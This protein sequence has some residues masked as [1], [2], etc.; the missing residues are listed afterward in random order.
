[1]ALTKA[2]SCAHVI[3]HMQNLGEA[4]FVAEVKYDGER[5][6]V[7]F[8]RAAPAGKQIT[9]YSKS[10][11]NSTSDR[12][13]CHDILLSALGVK[14]PTSS[15]TKALWD[16]CKEFVPVDSVILDSELLV[17]NE[18]TETIEPFHAARVF[19]SEAS[20]ST[21]EAISSARK[22][23]MLVFFDIMYLNGDS[24]INLPYSQRRKILESVIRPIPN[25][26]NVSETRIFKL[27]AASESF[28][29]GGSSGICGGVDVV[30]SELRKHFLQVCARPAE[31]LVCKGL[32][33]R[34]E[35][36]RDTLWMKLKKDYIEGFG[37]T[38]DFTVVGGS[39]RHDLTEY[40]GITRKDDACLLNLFFVAC[41]TNRG[42][43]N[44]APRFVV[45]F[46]F[47]AGFSRESLV[48]FSKSTT[49]IRYPPSAASKLSYSIANANAFKVDFYFDP[50]LAVEMKGGGFECRG[51]GRWALRGPRYLRT[52]SPDRGW[53]STVTYQELAAMGTKANQ[54][55]SW[56]TEYDKL[57]AV[58]IKIMSK[59]TRKRSSSKFPLKPPLRPKLSLSESVE[60]NISRGNKA[61]ELDPRSSSKMESC[62]VDDCFSIASEVSWENTPLSKINRKDLMLQNPLVYIPNCEALYTERQAFEILKHILPDT[63]VEDVRRRM[64]NSLD[65]LL[66]CT[67]WT[68]TGG[69]QGARAGIVLVERASMKQSIVNF[70]IAKNLTVASYCRP[71]ILLIVSVDEL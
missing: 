57:S 40:L 14:P 15:S 30:C 56:E 21:D 37:D 8:N 66:V 29:D 12:I 70:L 31:G 22:H 41:Q 35:P 42:S 23:Y 16:S 65:A 51:S 49:P 28:L 58:D 63:C 50:P 47:C 11:R 43:M 69:R 13:L 61:I 7:H 71:C 9:L 26:S 5:N 6:Q 46:D 45:L 53:W 38:A 54:A 39:Y 44:E 55:S 32:N 33:G 64:V 2:T 48:F 60:G 4:E 27:P 3:R 20:R 36:G 67:G 19:A 59:P 1:M 10:K 24:L 34:Y 18:D 68:E 62:D 17:Y 25:F 52:C